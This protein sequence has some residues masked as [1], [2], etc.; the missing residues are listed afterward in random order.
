MQIIPINIAPIMT[1][2]TIWGY[3]ATIPKATDITGNQFTL[4]T[5]Q[6][7]NGYPFYIGVYNQDITP[8]ATQ[9]YY[10]KCFATASENITETSYIP[11]DIIGISTVRYAPTSKGWVA[12]IAV[13]GTEGDT[14][15][16]L[17]FQRGLYDGSTYKQAVIF[18]VI[19]DNPITIDSTGTAYFTFAIEFD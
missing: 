9:A 11:S 1:M 10:L 7:T 19:L 2:N 5:S 13:A 15:N 14:I 3:A 4:G 16:A 8:S 6:N 12:T 18:A 17:L